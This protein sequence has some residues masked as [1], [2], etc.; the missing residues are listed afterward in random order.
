MVAFP[1]AKLGKLRLNWDRPTG[2]SA[3]GGLVT[4][5]GMRRDD[6]NT[7]QPRR[8]P[9]QSM[10]TPPASRR[11]PST[12]PPNEPDDLAQSADSPHETGK[13]LTHTRTNENHPRTPS[14]ACEG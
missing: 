8:P 14:R 2:G 5:P 1:A 12:A 6:R 7:E 13:L 11:P 4:R 10:S 9:G 3:E